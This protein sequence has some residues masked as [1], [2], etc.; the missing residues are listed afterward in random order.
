MGRVEMGSEP[1][2]E[3]RLLSAPVCQAWGYSE[4]Q[5]AP[6]HASLERTIWWPIQTLNM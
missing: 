5:E 4:P 6:A 3:M 1:E 2:H